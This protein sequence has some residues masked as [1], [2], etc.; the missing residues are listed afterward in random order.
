MMIAMVFV[1][2]FKEMMRYTRR[3]PPR[4][5]RQQQ[6]H[7]RQQPAKRPN[8]HC[9]GPKQDDHCAEEDLNMN[10]TMMTKTMTMTTSK[11]E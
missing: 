9:V 10:I 1:C 2:Y 8:D 11:N 3:Q 6:S 7:R 4:Q 5:Q